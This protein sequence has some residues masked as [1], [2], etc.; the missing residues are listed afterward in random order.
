MRQPSLHV[1]GVNAA[2][3]ALAVLLDLDGTLMD[4]FDA[5]VE[6]MNRGMADAGE[7]P[8]KA[9]ELRPLVGIPVVVQLGMLRG[10]AGPK[11]ERIGET[12]YRHFMRH[13]EG[14]VRLY[15]GVK[16]TL[17][18]M[19]ARMIG[20][21]T[22]RRREVARLMIR[23]A[24]IE[25]YF[26]A[27]TGGDEVARPKPSPDLPLH[28]AKALGVPAPECVVVG[29]S[30]VD[31]LAGR[32]AGMRTVAATYGYGELAALRDAGPDAEITRFAALPRA[33][34]ALEGRPTP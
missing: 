13:V 15:P 17:A 33:L 6:T 29:D 24:G 12:Y 16:E 27:I 25:T 10:I 34:A 32:A 14:G 28:A 30:P 31:V 26:R 23:V 20:T 18:K 7:P 22:T 5:I 3:V 8:L 9:E 2:A 11:A 21:M 1:A 4:T 19:P